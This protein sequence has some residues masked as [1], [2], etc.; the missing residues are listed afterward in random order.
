[1]VP[2]GRQ[3][4]P[5]PTGPPWSLGVRQPNPA[6]GLFWCGLQA[7]TAVTFLKG[8]KNKDYDTE[9]TC[10]TKSLK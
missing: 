10:G 9:T 7:K 5:S 1:M 2:E 3:Q 8:H 4:R 6:W